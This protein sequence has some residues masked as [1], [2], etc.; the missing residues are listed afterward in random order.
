VSRDDAD[1]A[2]AATLV[3]AVR[4]AIDHGRQPTRLP[5]AHDAGLDELVDELVEL[6]GFAL[7]L[8]QGDLDRTLPYRGTMAGAFKALQAAL[9]HLTWQ[10]QRVAA[11]DFTQRVDFMGDFSTAF[12]SMVVAL[13]EA[14]S[15]LA[16]RNQEL[17]ELNALLEKQAITDALTGTFNRR[18]FNDL[19]TF[20][21][22]R[23]R[24]YGQP[25]SL[26]ILDVDHFKRVNDTYGHA[27]GDAVLRELAEIVS[28]E[29]RVVDSLARWGGEE[30]VVLSPGVAGSG[31]AELAER[32]RAMVGAHV[33]PG[34]GRVT[35][36]MGVTEY[37]SGDTPDALF[38][39]ADAALFRAKEG[40][41]DRVVLVT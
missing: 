20:E 28:A 27:V 26:F 30:F 29:I 5:E 21:V 33:F 31:S 35:V 2:P 32:V 41:R 11:G 36:S 19:A 4:V 12:N 10:T 7:A 40:G 3:E 1:A 17:Q 8:A 14:R 39:R 38:A 23:A 9:R 6:S 16:L 13:E 18:K 24:R 22:A 15:E 37:A 34:V 25:L